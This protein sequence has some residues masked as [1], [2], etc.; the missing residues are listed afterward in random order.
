CTSGLPLDARQFSSNE[1]LGSC[2]ATRFAMGEHDPRRTNVLAFTTTLAAALLAAGAGFGQEEPARKTWITSPTARTDA[3]GIPLPEG[4][5]A[6]L[7]SARF[8]FDGYP[9]CA[10]AFSPDGQLVAVGGTRSV[11]I[12]KTATAGLLRRVP[13]PDGH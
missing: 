11:S 1:P 7:G 10:P 4:A 2:P 5:I 9:Y 13:L 6:R 12:F 8:R 3:D